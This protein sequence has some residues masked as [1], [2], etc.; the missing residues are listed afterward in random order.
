M[1]AYV[2][3]CRSARSTLSSISSRSKSG[4]RIAGG[5]DALRAGP[6]A[7]ARTPSRGSSTRVR[8]PPTAG[9]GCTT[10]GPACSR[11]STPLPDDA[12]PA[13]CPARAAGTATA[14]RSSSR[15]R[16]SSGLHDQA[17]DRGLRHRR[18]QPA[19]PRLGAALRRGLV[20]AHRAVGHLDRHRPTPTGRSSTTTSSRSGGCVRQMW[21]KGLLYEGHRVTPY[22]ARCG[23]ALSS[24]EVG[25]PGLPRRRRPVGVRAVPGH[26]RAAT[27]IPPTCW[28]GPPRRGR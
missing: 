7:S 20:G 5:S 17:R 23:T 16:R 14:C 22:C 9:P 8:R 24:H 15:S 11:T 18:V 1:A 28:C 26:R 6:R 3:P 10:C 27:A 2:G 13:T 21:D 4:A 19:L 12:G 25:Q